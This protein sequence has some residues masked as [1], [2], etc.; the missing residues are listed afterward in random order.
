LNIVSCNMIMK[1][2]WDNGD[3]DKIKSVNQQLSRKGN[4]TFLIYFHIN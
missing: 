2:L 3:V 1:S 4:D